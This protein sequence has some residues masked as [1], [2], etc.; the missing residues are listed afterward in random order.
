MVLILRATM[1][2]TIGTTLFEDS[3]ATFRCH[4][5]QLNC[6]HLCFNQFMPTNMVRFWYWQIIFSV[7]V[8]PLFKKLLNSSIEEEKFYLRLKEQEVLPYHEF[9]KLIR[10]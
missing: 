10:T 3:E 5:N 7:F 1:T 8:S 9:R 4:T 6:A 2:F